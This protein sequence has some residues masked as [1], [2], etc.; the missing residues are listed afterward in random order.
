MDIFGLGIES[1]CDE[2]GVAII[3]NGEEVISN[4]LF[5]QIESHR[6]YGGVVP[7]HA[8]RMHLEKFPSLIQAALDEFKKKNGK[9]RLSYI[10]VT[11]RPGLIGSLLMGYNAALALSS[12]HQVPVIPIHHLEAHFYASSIDKK[13]PA[14]PFIGL[15]LSGGNSSLF[16][17][18]GLGDM[19][20]I[21]DTYDDAAGEALDKAASLLGLEYPGGPSIQQEAEKFIKRND[22][23]VIPQI[24]KQNPF[25]KILK[26]QSPEQFDFSFS[27]LKT[28][29][30]YYTQKNPDLDIQRTAYYYQERVIEII[31]RN[32]EN[33]VKNLGISRVIAAGGVTANKFLRAGLGELA[34]RHSLDLRIPPIYLCTDNGA[35]VGALGYHYFKEGSWPSIKKVSSSKSFTWE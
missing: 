12:I 19:Q 29:L 27:G 20:I 17:V 35:M 8:S 21:G 31:L 7:E 30:L 6:M 25:P 18:R 9:S 14:Y 26:G 32:L 24:N 33:A 15:L 28:S 1:S 34:H 22:A 13:M 2:T 23:R 4:P 11:T 3:K 16:L 5:S 10:A